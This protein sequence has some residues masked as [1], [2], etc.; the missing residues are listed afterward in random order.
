MYLHTQLW[1][2]NRVRI[3]C[4]C[5]MQ[6]GTCTHRSSTL[7]LSFLHKQKVCRGK[8]AV[9]IHASRWASLRACSC[10]ASTAGGVQ[11]EGRRAA[12]AL[13]A[14]LLL[15][16]LQPNAACA[17]DTSSMSTGTASRSA[18]VEVVGSMVSGNSDAST[19]STNTQVR[20][21][22]AKYACVACACLRGTVCGKL[23]TLARMGLR[24]AA[25]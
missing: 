25:W 23:R 13:C 18:T 7:P 21:V 2:P 5:R 6:V 17:M 16:A 20:R 3:F 14:G 12:A 4:C 1:T 10:T 11:N 8:L 22:A 15:Q 24:Y 19:L 9:T